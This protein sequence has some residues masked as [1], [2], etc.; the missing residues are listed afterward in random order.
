MFT[1]LKRFFVLIFFTIFSDDI[2]CDCQTVNV[3]SNKGG[4]QGTYQKLGYVNGRTSWNSS[5]GVA[6]WFSQNYEGWFFGGMNILGQDAAEL[7]SF[8]TGNNSCFYNISGDQWQY[9]NSA[10]GWTYVNDGDVSIQCLSGN[11]K[12]IGPSLLAYS[13]HDLS[14]SG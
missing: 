9:Y 4:V 12:M 5:T 1:L 2:I 7:L 14:K 6:V 3:I 8:D 10:Q 13:N 11:F